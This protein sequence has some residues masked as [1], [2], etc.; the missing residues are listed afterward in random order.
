MEKQLKD[1]TDIELK[2]M[3]YDHIAQLQVL[4]NN[5]NA[6]NQELARRLQPAQPQPA[7]VIPRL[8]QVNVV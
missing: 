3:A 8:G 4:Q 2:A 6:I 7:Q 1:F 5:L